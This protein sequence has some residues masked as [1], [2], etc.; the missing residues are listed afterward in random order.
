MQFDARA[1]K[2]QLGAGSSVR[3][4]G[5]ATRQYFVVG[6]KRLVSK[7]GPDTVAVII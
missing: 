2:Q 4:H 6:G 5:G 3:G 1:R 7:L